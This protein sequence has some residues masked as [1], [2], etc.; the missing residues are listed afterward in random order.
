[1][2]G[3]DAVETSDLSRL[4]EGRDLAYERGQSLQASFCSPEIGAN[5]AIRDGLQQLV[6]PMIRG[7]RFF[8]DESC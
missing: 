4:L 2:P 3:W 8:R 7:T 5:A 6:R 1:M